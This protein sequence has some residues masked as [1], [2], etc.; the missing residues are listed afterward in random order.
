MGGGAGKSS[1]PQLLLIA[2]ATPGVPGEKLGWHTGCV[3]SM[4]VPFM[5][6]WCA[7]P[8][9]GRAHGY[10]QEEAA[11]STGLVFS[12]KTV[13]QTPCGNGALGCQWGTSAGER[14][15][16][17]DCASLGCRKCD[18]S[19]MK[20][21]LDKIFIAFHSIFHAHCITQLQR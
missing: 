7:D 14:I 6:K 5:Q 13:V 18:I 21:G 4:M 15:F 16:L 12:S 11:H 1:E 9:Q 19:F 8:Q 17:L 2:A 20:H 3:W 10:R